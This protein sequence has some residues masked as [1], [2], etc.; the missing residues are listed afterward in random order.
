VNN[1]QHG[2]WSNSAQSDEPLLGFIV[3]DIPDRYGVRVL[4]DCRSGLKLDVMSLEV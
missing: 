3:Q 1:Q 4:E 2:S